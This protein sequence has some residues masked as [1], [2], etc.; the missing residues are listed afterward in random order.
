MPKFKKIDKKTLRFI[1][2]GGSGQV[3]RNM[4]AYECGRDIVILDC[5]VGFPDFETPGVDAAIPDI[6]YLEE[7]GKL[8]NIR[9][10]IITHAHYDHFGALPHLLPKLD[11]PV[12]ASKL[13]LE[14]A[15]ATLDEAGIKSDKKLFEIDPDN[16]AFDL[17][18]FHI[19]PF[20]VCHSVPD[21]LGFLLS[22]PIG[23][24][25]HV[26]DYKFDWTPVDGR[27]FDVRKLSKLAGQE[28]P[29]LLASDCLGANTEGYTQSEKVLT[30]SIEKL[31]S[32]AEHQIFFTTVSSNISRIQQAVW[33]AVRHGRKVCFLGRSM[34]QSAL[35]ARKLGYLEVEKK[36][37]VHPKQA[38]R[39]DQSKLAYV[40]AGCYG[41]VGSSLERLA[42]GEHS[43]VEL[44]GKVAVI[45]S[46][47]P[48]PPG[49]KE[50]VDKVVDQLIMRGAE[51]SYYK[52]QD[53]MHVSGHGSALDIQ[54]LMGLVQSKYF[55]PIG[56]MPRHM[57]AYSKLAQEMGVPRENVFEL[58]AGEYLEFSENWKKGKGGKPPEK[59]EFPFRD[60]LVDGTRIG[61]VGD[62]VLRDRQLLADDGIVVLIVPIDPKTGNIS[63]SVEIATRGF[64]YVR[65]SRQIISDLVGIVKSTA[66]S[67]PSKK[68][69]WGELKKQLSTNVLNYIQQKTGR[70]PLILPVI[71][72]V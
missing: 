23:N 30:D 66:G 3:T 13:A 54:M 40:V 60:I 68:E 28:K 67:E 59:G 38:R 42:R 64:V 36:N 19:E 29:M 47:D 41:Q 43:L 34:E 12:Y 35:V 71:V 72:E 39:F 21:S 65:K 63:G 50:A 10:I 44:E 2:L 27:L 33:A 9:G 69:D 55:V 53:N 7:E 14:F 26:S 56:G 51:V 48:E 52:I 32:E 4:F 37:L 22:T 16:G 17:G 25:F 5:G 18:C 6:S 24:I 57:Q 8:S 58:Q 49:S 62:V 70:T 1:P 15:R 46:G 45:F 20:R 61:D 11:A 31:I